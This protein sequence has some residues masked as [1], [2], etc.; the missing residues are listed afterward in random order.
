MAVGLVLLALG[1][2]ILLRAGKLA[3]AAVDLGAGQPSNVDGKGGS[4]TTP[5]PTRG[6]GSGAGGGGGAW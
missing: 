2:A 5:R 1:V 4:F 6:G 3:G